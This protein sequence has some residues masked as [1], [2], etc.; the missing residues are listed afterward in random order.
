VA[1]AR[2]VAI[3]GVYA[4]AQERR[5]EKS[6]IGLL[7]EAAEGA[8]ADAGLSLKEVDGYWGDFPAGNAVW[9]GRAGNIAHQLDLPI[10]Y[11]G[12]SLGT[13]AVLEAA[14]AIR[15][16]LVETV[17]IPQGGARPRADG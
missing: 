12:S 1:R 17:I 7:M 8:L 3:V 11:A 6:A 2:D 5:S 9:G 4:T 15:E 16:G 10:H 13:L 14:A